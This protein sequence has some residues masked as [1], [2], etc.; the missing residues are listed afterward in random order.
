MDKGELVT[1]DKV[2]VPLNIEI[3]KALADKLGLGACWL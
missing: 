1:G 2:T 3:P